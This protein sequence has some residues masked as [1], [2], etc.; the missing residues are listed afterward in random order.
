MKIQ[1]KGKEIEV[2]EVVAGVVKK[3]ETVFYIQDAESKEWLYTSKAR[4][5]KLTAKLGSLE[6]VGTKYVGR[7]AKKASKPATPADPVA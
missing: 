7:A 6:A 2:S 5:D 3:S 4:L 1:F